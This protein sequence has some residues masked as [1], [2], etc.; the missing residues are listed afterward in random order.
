MSIFKKRFI[1]FFLCFVI[2]LSSFLPSSSVYA[3]ASDIA[4][5]NDQKGIV[6]LFVAVG[7][8]LGLTSINSCNTGKIVRHVKKTFSNV[9]HEVQSF[10]NNVYSVTSDFVY[11]VLD[12]FYSDAY[13]RPLSCSTLNDFN[14]ILVR[15]DSFVPN[16]MEGR[17]GTG[18]VSRLCNLE[19]G[20]SVSFTGA[21][22]LAYSYNYNSHFLNHNGK[23]LYIDNV[24]VTW[25]KFASINSDTFIPQIF[26]YA[27]GDKKS[28]HYDPTVGSVCSPMGFT[29]DAGVKDWDYDITNSSD[30]THSKYLDC[31]NEIPVSKNYS[32]DYSDN[33]VIHA[34]SIDMNCDEVFAG[35]VAV[36]VSAEDV[37]GTGS[38]DENGNFHGVR[39]DAYSGSDNVISHDFPVDTVVPD[40]VGANDGSIAG[41][42]SSLLSIFTNFWAKLR[43]LLQD[44]FTN[45][46]GLLKNIFGAIISNTRT[47]AS[48]IVAG[49]QD[50]VSSI[51]VVN[52][53]DFSLPNSAELDF[54]PLYINL[55]N[56][57]PFCVP[58]DLV[59]SFKMFS[60]AKQTPKFVVD[61]PSSNLIGGGK[62][63]IDFDKFSELAA[64][65]R[66]F[67][68]VFFIV[69]LVKKTKSLIGG[70]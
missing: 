19:F 33:L 46:L 16:T 7:S 54:K 17:L 23:K 52:S 29:V 70:E 36:P 11:G 44:I 35:N 58:W 56:K 20:Q 68:L 50:I 51:P 40:V 8:F 37:I 10:A 39:N 24:V 61:F 41:D 14:S 45:P 34:P 25:Y 42:N 49:V 55:S 48:S 4:L 22:G 5:L 18:Y 47:L 64:V 30:F 21:G 60:T 69:G 66:Y 65:L 31:S 2:F 67:V 43:K 6:A 27:N 32:Y 59:N 38:I 26:V 15:S 12:F 53:I 63:E 62:F 3:S 9:R 28:G 13:T 57:F 1:S